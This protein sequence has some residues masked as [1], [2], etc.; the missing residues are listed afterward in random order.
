MEGREVSIY[1]PPHLLERV[2]A[3]AKFEGRS[4]PDYIVHFLDT[5]M[6]REAGARLGIPSANAAG[7][8]GTSTGSQER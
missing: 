1:L 3:Q 4:V 7:S 2:E 8:F 6:P 5:L